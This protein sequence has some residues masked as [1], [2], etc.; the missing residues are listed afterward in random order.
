MPER[1]RGEVAVVAELDRAGLGAVEEL[2]DPAAVEGEQAVMAE[3]L[4]AGER[5]AGLVQVEEPEQAGQGAAEDLAADLEWVGLVVEVPEAAEELGADLDPEV[6]GLAAEVP[7][8]AE[9]LA[10]DLERADLAAEGREAEVPVEG[11]EGREE[12]LAVYLGRAV[13]E[14]A[15]ERADPGW[16]QNRGGGAPPRR[17]CATPWREELSGLGE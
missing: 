15:G 7:E 8:V 11:V 12:E 2:E 6:A 1:L 14:R 3:V 16:V 10:A 9:D 4:R 5:V 17:C 13:A